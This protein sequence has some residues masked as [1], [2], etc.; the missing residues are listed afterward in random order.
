MSQTRTEAV[1][2]PTGLMFKLYAD[3]FGSP[4]VEATGNSPQP[5]PIYPAGGDQPSVNPGSDTYP[6]DMAAA[7]GGD[8]KRFSIAVLNPS[9]AAQALK[10]EIKGVKLARPGTLWQMAPEKVGAVVAVGKTAEVEV[11]EKALGSMPGEVT[12]PPFS[13]NLYSYP[14]E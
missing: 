8:R 7:Y 10:L 2:N 12:A 1:Q 13:I 6:V 14:V 3:H 9:D 11:V 4:P 5:K